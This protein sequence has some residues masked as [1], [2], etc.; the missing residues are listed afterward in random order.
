MRDL[1]ARIDGLDQVLSTRI[2]DFAG[3]LSLYLLDR[4]IWANAQSRHSN[5]DIE[6]VYADAYAM[7]WPGD[8]ATLPGGGPSRERDRSS[9]SFEHIRTLPMYERYQAAIGH[10]VTLVHGF[11]DGYDTNGREARRRNMS[12]DIQPS[13]LDDVGLRNC[14]DFAVTPFLDRPIALAHAAAYNGSAELLYALGDDYGVELARLRDAPDSKELLMDY[15]ASRGYLDVLMCL[16]AAGNNHC[17]THAM[18]DAI[19]NGHLKVVA[20]LHLARDEGCSH[21]GFD[22]AYK[23]RTKQP[24]GAAILAF[25][26]DARG[27]GFTE[28]SLIEAATVG[29]L[30]FLRAA[31]SVPCTTRV[32]DAAAG[33]DQLDV[34]QFLHR[35]RAEGCSEAALMGGA[36]IG[37]LPV[38]TFLCTHYHDASHLVKAMT[39][40]A[41]HGHLHIVQYLHG[42]VPVGTAGTKPMNAALRK[43]RVEIVHFLQAHRPS[44]GCTSRALEDA[45]WNIDEDLYTFLVGVRPELLSQTTLEAAAG[46]GQEDIVWDHYARGFRSH[47]AMAWAAQWGEFDWVRQHHEVFNEPCT[48]EAT[49]RAA[50]QGFEEIASY[51]LAN[52]ASFTYQGI[53]KAA[54]N[55]KYATLA[56]LV[57]RDETKHRCNLAIARALSA[58]FVRAAQDIYNAAGFTGAL[59]G[60]KRYASLINPATEDL[61]ED[62]DVRNAEID[63]DLEYNSDDEIED[64]GEDSDYEDFDY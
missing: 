63:S 24:N 9:R 34:L 26:E 3:P 1:L 14:W 46:H 43:D 32:M 28:T 25:L 51:L 39:E 58:G 56:L 8:L 17:T 23:Q 59:A 10:S 4:G 62:L 60:W 61:P 21:H 5:A 12:F 47:R 40:A 53:Y 22:V 2:L 49:D 30:R 36:A 50:G 45:L 6:A 64:E 31:V 27:Y 42:L 44:E 13:S 52:G 38:V 55:Y 54:C 7:D 35:H 11:R 29:D 37:S 18:D 16:H 19:A 20:W 15:A 41:R 48:D 33:S 57:G